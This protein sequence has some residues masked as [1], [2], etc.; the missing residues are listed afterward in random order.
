VCTALARQNLALNVAEKGFSISVF[1][2][3]SSKTD[4]AVKR[5]HKEG[6]SCLQCCC[7]EARSSV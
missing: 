4:E 2:R 6:A 3:S 1:N 7:I 5:A